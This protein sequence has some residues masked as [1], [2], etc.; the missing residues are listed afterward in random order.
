M[1]TVTA[2]TVDLLERALVEEGLE[3]LGGGLLALRVL[4]LDSSVESTFLFKATTT[5]V[6]NLAGRRLQIDRI[7]LIVRH[8]HLRGDT[9]YGSHV[10]DEYV[11]DSRPMLDVTR[12]VVGLQAAGSTWET[13]VYR[14]VTT[15]TQDD[16]RELR[17]IGKRA[18]YSVVTDEQTAGRGRLTRTWQAPAGT[19]VLMTIALPLPSDLAALPLAIGVTVVRILQRLEPALRLKWPNDIVVL[20]AGRIRK[21]GGLI[22]EIDHDA[23]LI[24]IGLNVEMRSEELPTEQAISFAQLGISVDREALITEILCAFERWQRPTI[25]DYQS[26]CSTIGELV[27]VQ[28][29]D[30]SIVRGR[31][32]GIAYDGALILD[33]DGR[34]QRIATGDVQQVRG[35]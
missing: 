1:C 32:I 29:V 12:L 7:V 35:T 17:T 2:Q 5:K 33:V 28:A 14:P 18:P 11:P 31:A 19:S 22:V 15:S 3:A 25:D 8:V 20:E 4:L 16:A 26:L 9:A 21:L 23:A 10:T 6:G 13:P 30:G 24:G 34:E 27:D